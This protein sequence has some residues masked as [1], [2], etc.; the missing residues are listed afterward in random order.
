MT[1]EKRKKITGETSVANRA[2][3]DMLEMNS[4]PY[5]FSQS[6]GDARVAKRDGLTERAHMLF[7]LILDNEEENILNISK[8]LSKH[9]DIKPCDVGAVYFRANVIYGLFPKDDRLVHEDGVQKAYFQLA[10]IAN[11]AEMY[12]RASEFYE[13]AGNFRSAALNAES[14]GLTDRAINLFERSGR[15]YDAARVALGIRMSFPEWATRFYHHTLGYSHTLP[16]RTVDKRMVSRAKQLYEKA[17]AQSRE[18]LGQI[19]DDNYSENGQKNCNDLLMAAEDARSVGLNGVA[20]QMLYITG[21]I[22]QA[23]VKNNWTWIVG[24]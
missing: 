10:K 13:K 23:Y 18:L 7:S 14:A 11:E 2:I 24:P 15:F 21:K 16:Q 3:E 1:K 4:Q 22:H 17:I 20:Q 5:C 12:D 9:C 8:A 6:I 19:N